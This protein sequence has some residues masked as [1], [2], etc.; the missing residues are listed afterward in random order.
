MPYTSSLRFDLQAPGSNINTWGIVLNNGVFTLA[1]TAISGRLVLSLSG[2]VTLTVGNGVTDQARNAMI[3]VTGGTGGSIVIPSVTKI[4]Q[5][6]NGSSGVL[7]ITA[8]ATSASLVVGESS[9]VMCDGTNVTKI[10]PQGFPTPTNNSDAANKAYVDSIAFSGTGALPGISPATAGQYVTNDGTLAFW[11]PAGFQ[12]IQAVSALYVVLAADKEKQLRGT[13]TF[14]ISFANVTTLGNSFCVYVSNVGTGDIT[15]S[16]ATIDGLSS[17][18]VYPGETRMLMGNGSV[19][20]SVVLSP[21]SKTFTAT[22]VFTKPPGYARFGLYGWSGAAGGQKNLGATTAQGGGGGGCLETYIEAS[23]VGA[24]ETVTIGA[25]GAGQTVFSPSLNP[26]G[27]TSLGSI[28]SIAGAPSNGNGGGI[29]T[30]MASPQFLNP[31]L[32]TAAPSGATYGGGAHSNNCSA[33]SGGSVF[34][35]AAGG[36]IDAADVVRAPGTSIFGGD[37]GAASLASSGV[38]GSIPAGGGGATRNG[39]KAGDGARGELR[40]W[41][42][43]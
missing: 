5:V 2:S 16:G 11:G 40:L 21:F 42:V 37:A 14:T 8:G 33:A 27:A 20:T 23:D 1:D 26:G 9:F 10:I 28:V 29:G 30:A 17:Y 34:G 22:G 15:L 4:Y 35:G 12:G 43:A 38:N 24:T 41:G 32:A 3:H 7:I 13:G 6:L 18:I 25:G 31:E 36:G 19:I 39:A